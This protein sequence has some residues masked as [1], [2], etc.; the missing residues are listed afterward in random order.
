MMSTLFREEIPL[1]T[2]S[3]ELDSVKRQFPNYD[4]YYVAS[5]CIKERREFFEQLWI[6]YERYAD[7]HFLAEVKTHFHQRTWEMYIGCVLLMRHYVICSEDQGPDFKIKHRSKTIWI[8]AVAATCGDEEKEDSVPEFHADGE[9]H[10][11]N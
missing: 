1:V 3:A 11:Y 5:G 10:E 6:W 7:K 9:V 2:T 8:E 4:P